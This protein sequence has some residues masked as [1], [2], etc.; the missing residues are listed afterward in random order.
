MSN[1]QRAEMILDEAGERAQEMKLEPY[2]ISSLEEIEAM[3]PFPFPNI[4]SYRPSN[5]EQIGSLFCDSSGFGLPSE[6]ALT[7]EQLIAKLEVGFA[8]AIIEVGQFQLYIGV[9]RPEVQH[10]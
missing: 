6:S 5:W 8:Y 1:T 9:F 4:G 3:P 10:A 7:P 2:L